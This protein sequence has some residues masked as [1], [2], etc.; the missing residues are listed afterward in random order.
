MAGTNV[1]DIHQ[2]EATS[3]ERLTLAKE[4]MRRARGSTPS[5]PA[6]RGKSYRRRAGSF[7]LSEGLEYVSAEVQGTYLYR[8][9]VKLSYPEGRAARAQAVC[10]CPYS[11]NYGPCKHTWAVLSRLEEALEEELQRRPSQSADLKTVTV[12]RKPAKPEPAWQRGLRYLD[13]FLATA[14]P[15]AL[16][17]AEARV[18]WRVKVARGQPYVEAYEQLRR[19]KGYT[20]GRKL[21]PARLAR[22]DDLWTRP[23]VRAAASLVQ[24]EESAGYGYYRSVEQVFPHDLVLLELVGSPHV[25]WLDDPEQPVRVEHARLGLSLEPRSRSRLELV[26]TF[27]GLPLDVPVRLARGSQV[28]VV[29]DPEEDTIRVGRVD[30]AAFELVQRLDAEARLFPRKGREQLLQRLEPLEA[31]LPVHI[32]EELQGE[33]QAADE[34]LR[35]LLT[36]SE[37]SLRVDARVRPAGAGLALVPGAEHAE[38]TAWADGRRVGLVRDPERERAAALDLLSELGLDPPEVATESPAAW[39]WFMEGE[40][41]L[42]FVARVQRADPADLVTEWPEGE[43]LSVSREAKAEDLRVR[44]HDRR[45][46]FGLDGE[47]E[48]DGWRVSL[49]AL[50]DSL[51]RGER[52]LPLD[53]NRW[54]RVSQLLKQRLSALADVVHRPKKALEVDGTA[55]PVLEELLKVAGEA[56]ICERW[57]DLQARLKKAKRVSTR[58]P[59]GLDAELRPY[60][61]E[62]FAWLKRLSTWGVGACLADDMGLGKTVQAIAILLS[63]ARQGP[64]LVVAPTSVGANWL[65]EVHLFAP[66]LQPVLYRET[67]RSEDLD[68]GPR[69]VVVI[70]YGLARVDVDRLKQVEWATLVLDEAQQVK[71]ATTKTARALREL[72]AD[73][74]LALTGTPIENHLGELWSLFRLLSPGLLGSW[75]SFKERFAAPIER[76]GDSERR[77]ALARVLR[78]FVLRRTKQEV[79]QDLPGRTD[80]QVEIE[81]SKRELRLYEEARLQAIAELVSD[82]GGEGRDKRFQVLAALTRLRQLACHPRLV[83]A[84]WRGESAK[85]KAFLEVVQELRAGEHRALVFSQFTSHL[86]L[87]R[88]ALDKQDVSYLYLDGQTPAKRRQKLVD[89]FQQGEGELFLIS[90]KAGGNGLN[91]TAADYVVHL[92]PWWNPA[93]EDQAT[94]RAHRIGQTRPVTVYRLVTTSTIEEQI[95]ALHAQKR[96]LVA[97]VLGGSSKAGKLS[98]EDL[99]ALIRG[100]EPSPEPQ[101]RRVARPGSASAASQPRRSPPEGGRLR[102]LRERHD[103]TQQE[104]GHLFGVTSPTISRWEH[105]RLPVKREEQLRQLERLS[106]RALRRRLK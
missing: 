91:L 47:V 17:Q 56:E 86:A 57:E 90:L 51:R 83:D 12:A 65:R 70:S 21:S 63:R 2:L 100:E 68:L 27:G 60:Q 76:D 25:T 38:L 8:V 43:S 14:G 103:L 45:D 105:G 48:V 33:P 75:E 88:E 19:D 82:A 58:P 73:W 52:Y 24:N 35:L 87:L 15:E 93:V 1:V 28:L 84:S 4:A 61:Q 3:T 69:D 71:N 79:L 102:A 39:S 6:R 50:L 64:A 34:R 95:L 13:R 98:T 94:D 99:L 78:P 49:A 5:G 55:G 37:H 18:V 53:G 104:L 46:W 11:D 81:L 59:R 31:V 101:R 40:E 29:A 30:P 22:S 23:D 74:R 54:L 96:D 77:E 66:R 44:V 16:A 97:G 92:D 67:D 26:P 62:G 36:P 32:P 41:A 89:A 42:D 9:L 72:S 106:S 85:L 80:V 7:D 20:K 10:S